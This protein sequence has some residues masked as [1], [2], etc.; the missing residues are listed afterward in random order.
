M[1]V[2]S[3]SI[4]PL[5]K[6]KFK[7]III[8][9]LLCMTIITAFFTFRP[10]KHHALYNGKAYSTRAENENDIRNFARFFGLSLDYSTEKCRDI[11]IPE[12]FDMLLS[13]YDLIQG[14]V[15]LSL[16]RY[17]GKSCSLHTWELMNNGRPADSLLRLII[18]DDIIIGG[19][20]C[21]VEY[22]GDIRNFAGE[23]F[24]LN[25]QIEQ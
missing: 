25:Q 21:S 5:S 22:G 2:L 23:K 11:I 13:N 8:T 20:I 16:S 18:L 3:F 10:E 12:K 24:T 9:V 4:K 7:I 6:R 17:A 1:F 15:G 19:D 14:S